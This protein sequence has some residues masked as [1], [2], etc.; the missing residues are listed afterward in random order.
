MAGINKVILVGNLGQD[1][2]K[3]LLPSGESLVNISVA[4]SEN[5]IDKQTGER[6]E[7]TEWH[8]VA[9]FGRQAD[10]VAQY[11]RKGSKVYL[12]GKLQTRKWTDQNGQER[13]S[14]EV[15]LSGVGSTV[16]LLDSRSGGQSDFGGDYEQSAYGNQPNYP[17]QGY[18]QQGGWQGGGYAQGAYPQNNPQGSQG[19]WNQAPQNAYGNQ[20][21]RQAS[22]APARNAPPAHVPEAEYPNPSTRTPRP[23]VNPPA[24]DHGF[25]GDDDLPF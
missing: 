23:P 22:R 20:A 18:A 15:V 11:C 6:K 9:I 4:T 25:D 8:R 7:R 1:P 10:V 14:T 2:E 3:K 13:Y 17:Q 19:Q 24:L 12:E 5:W 16:Q 21:P